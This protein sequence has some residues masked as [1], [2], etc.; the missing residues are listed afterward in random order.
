MAR[1]AMEDPDGSFSRR[2]R[3]GTYVFG[4]ILAVVVAT[5]GSLAYLAFDGGDGM[6]GILIEQ[7]PDPAYEHLFPYY[8][9]LGVISQYRLAG[10]ARGGPAGHALMYIK[11]ACKDE[12]A[13]FPQLRRCRSVATDL[14]D[15]EHGVGVSVNRFLKNVNWLAIPGYKLF[16]TG[17]LEQGER[18][19]QVHFDAT[20]RRAIDAGVFDGVEL[21]DFTP[22]KTIEEFAAVQTIGTDLALRFAR[23]TFVSRLPVTEAMLDEIIAFLNDKNREYATGAADYNWSGVYDNCVHTVRNALAAANVWAPISVRATKLWHLLNMAVPANEV[24]NL[25]MLGAE[26][27]IEDYR[28]IQEQGPLR[29]AL[30]EFNWLPT[31][32]GALLKTLPVQA[33]NDLFDTTFRLFALQS[34]FRRGKRKTALRLL[35]DERF[36]DLRANLNHFRDKYDAVLA[37]HHE[38]F[39]GLARVRGTPYRRVRRKHYEYIKAQRTEVDTM[40]EQ[41]DRL[42]TAGEEPQPH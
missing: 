7:V 30:H 10:G 28:R 36:F 39:D 17:N 14:D 11:G 18:L 33:P 37:S 4:A 6:E 25:A 1:Y 19:T 21:H 42:E 32:H 2:R 41:L 22:E 16:Y 27:P 24:I 13:P 23:T 29:D 38:G 20:V 34:P 8:V 3:F 26:G 35:S 5:I 31:R 15:P 40:L 9:D 12:D